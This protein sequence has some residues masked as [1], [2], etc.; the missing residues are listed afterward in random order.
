M[1]ADEK[2]HIKKNLVMLIKNTRCTTLFLAH[3]E[4]NGI[5]TQEE[6]EELVCNAILPNKQIYL[7]LRCESDACFQ[8]QN[9]PM[10]NSR[11]LY[12]IIRT[13]T[14]SY[15]CLLAALEETLQTEASWILQQK[16]VT[17]KNYGQIIVYKNQ[18]HGKGMRSNKVYLGKF[19]GREVAVK[20]I[21]E[22]LSQAIG[23]VEI[24]KKLSD[25]ENVIRYFMAEQHKNRVY[26]ALELCT[27][28]L[29]DQVIMKVLDISEKRILKQATKG[30]EFLHRNGIIH[31]DLKPSNLLLNDVGCVKISDFGFSK[32]IED[33]KSVRSITSLIG[34]SG[35]MA[36]E[37]INISNGNCYD[38]S[39][40]VIVSNAIFYLK[41]KNRKILKLLESTDIL[42]YK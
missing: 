16:N 29:E 9:L 37:I 10:E 8:E 15:Q 2:E 17:F 38:L 19:D 18:V 23:E 13:K 25:H 12:S 36:P 5:L 14:N 1:E 32:L 40:P 27:V 33:A 31:R 41:F 6:V 28:N 11:L 26:I 4:Q 42:C 24:L 20:M 35:W 34:T 22:N 3:L 39:E 30:L 21:D 7:Y